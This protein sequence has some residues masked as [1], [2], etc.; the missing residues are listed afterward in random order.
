LTLEKLKETLQL[1]EKTETEKLPINQKTELLNKAADKM[2]VYIDKWKPIYLKIEAGIKEESLPQPPYARVERFEKT[3]DEY[4]NGGVLLYRQPMGNRKVG[5][6]CEIW[7]LSSG[8]FLLVKTV[9]HLYSKGYYGGYKDEILHPD[10]WTWKGAAEE[11]VDNTKL[12][13]NLDQIISNFVQIIRDILLAVKEVDESQK[14]TLFYILEFL[15]SKNN[16]IYE[17]FENLSP[18]SITAI[19]ADAFNI[20]SKDPLLYS[21]SSDALAKF[22]KNGIKPLIKM[23][24]E[25]SERDQIRGK[26]IEALGKIGDGE[27]VAEFLIR[28]VEESMG[29]ASTAQVVAT[30]LGDISDEKAYLPLIK[31]LK[32]M[33]KKPSWKMPHDESVQHYKTIESTEDALDKIKKKLT[34]KS[35]EPLIQTINDPDNSMRRWAIIGLGEIGDGR[36]I[37]P[38]IRILNEKVWVTL[39]IEAVRA[40]GKID[41]EKTIAALTQVYKK[42]KNKQLQ[43][44]AGEVL[45]KLGKRPKSW[46]E[47]MFR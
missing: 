43:A 16:S 46:R 9:D 18:K 1:I 13:V 27:E 32:R 22:G 36:A 47:K 20:L 40:L 29:F 25:T 23:F 28:A 11:T 24:N 14:E 33:H 12:L 39:Q 2:V 10:T 7:L 6:V 15:L 3:N 17:V 37:E 4:V 44:V 8:R 38:L 45:D 19:G 42:E 31:Y 35:V 30:T 41:D 26:I 21:I 5:E 34:V